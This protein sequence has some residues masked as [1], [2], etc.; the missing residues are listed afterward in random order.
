MH[1]LRFVLALG[2]LA[3]AFVLVIADAADARRAG[4]FGSRGSRTYAPPPTT[5]TAPNAA[6]PIQRSMTQKGQP[7]TV[8]AARPATPT[9]TG[10][11]F[12][13][14]GLVGGLIA[15]FL[16]AGLIGLLLGQGLL[17]GLGS[18]AAF[19]GLALQI[20][21]IALV[22]YLLWTW[23]QRRSQPALAG[24]PSLRDM[25]PSASRPM[26]ALGGG[27]PAPAAA[28]AAGHDEIGTQ[29]S[30]FDTFERLL[31]EIQTAYGNEDMASLRTRVTPEA[32]SYLAEE[33]A[34]NASNGVVNRISNV[35][36]LQGDLAEAWREGNV[37]YAT[38]AMRFS[39]VDQMVDRTSGRVVEG[40][41][42]PQEI[43][44]LW[45]FMRTRG[46]NWL[47]SAVQET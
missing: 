37:E 6:Q 34:G 19:L 20:G 24:G 38:V 1:R 27:A 30:D 33:L 28:S 12:N 25:A 7:G 32:L 36:L 14:P 5:Q 4:G 43:T 47:L 13:R 26:S 22:G 42:A 17:G 31:G 3:T 23:W 45:T 18:L 46:G 29:A 2:A 9:P 44:E 10:G 21:L 39:Q 16:G 41:A 15:G 11:L 35:K 8:A 40:D